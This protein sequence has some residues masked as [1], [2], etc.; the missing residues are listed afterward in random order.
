VAQLADRISAIAPDPH[1]AMLMSQALFGR[2]VQREAMTLAFD[3]VFRLLAWMFVLA[4]VMVP[5]CRTSP[6]VPPAEPG[7]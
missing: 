7:H 6:D 5:F 1:Q 3:D 4:L 2:L